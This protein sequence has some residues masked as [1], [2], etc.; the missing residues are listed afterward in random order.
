MSKKKKSC[1]LQLIGSTEIIPFNSQLELTRW[2]GILEH[3]RKIIT[4]RCK[5]LGYDVTFDTQIN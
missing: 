3:D 5:Q 1:S 4:K 2:L